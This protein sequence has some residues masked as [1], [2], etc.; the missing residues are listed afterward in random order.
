MADQTSEIPALKDVLDGLDIAGSM[1]SADA[2]HTR[3]ETAQHLVTERNAHYLLTVKA[4][5]PTLLGRVKALPWAQAPTLFTETGRGH[6]RYERRTV[7]V[8]TAPRIAFSHL[9]HVLRVH[10]WVKELATGTVRHTCAYV[11][12]SLPAER[13]DAARLGHLLRAT[14]GSRRCTTCGT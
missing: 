9:C 6:G 12:T 13:A 10:R 2:L 11:I 1:V 8:V 14:G 4:T 7:K 3:T 5:Q